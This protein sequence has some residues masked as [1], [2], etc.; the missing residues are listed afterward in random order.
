MTSHHRPL[1]LCGGRGENSSY[2][3]KACISIAEKREGG[4]NFVLAPKFSGRARR[5]K[6]VIPFS[7]GGEG[8]PLTRR[9][10]SSQGEPPKTGLSLQ[11]PVYYHCFLGPSGRKK[12]GSSSPS[13][14]DA[15][16]RWGIKK[17]RADVS[18]ESGI[19]GSFMRPPSG[20]KAE[21]EKNVRLLFVKKKRTTGG[22]K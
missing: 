7:N 11:N 21:E 10:F 5:K 3:L 17:E 6:R 9:V 2:L 22:K 1:L 15:T 19:P 8:G 13:V 18:K 14:K 4:R 16:R 12:S 20:G